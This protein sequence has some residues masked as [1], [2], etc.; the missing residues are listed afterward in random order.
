LEEKEMPEYSK[1][2][3]YGKKSFRYNF[4]DALLEWI[5]G[6]DNAEYE[7]KKGDVIDC[8]GLSREGWKKNSAEYIAQYADEIDEESASLLADFKRYG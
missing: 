8:I 1:V 3:K 5:H 7:W 4:T 2:V 6:K